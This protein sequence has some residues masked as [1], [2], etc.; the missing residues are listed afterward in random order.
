MNNYNLTIS[1][2]WKVYGTNAKEPV[3][4]DDDEE[5][6][7]LADKWPEHMAKSPKQIREYLDKFV[8]GQD[9]TKKVL[10]VAAYARNMRIFS[11]LPQV[12]AVKGKINLEKSNVL[13]MGPTG[14]GKTFLLKV[15]AEYLDCATAVQD[16]S[17]LSETGYVGKNANT[18]IGALI[19]DAFKYISKNYHKLGINADDDETFW[20]AVKHRVEHGIVYFDEFD[21]IRAKDGQSHDISTTA[22]Q[23]ELLKLIEGD[24]ITIDTDS[25]TSSLTTPFNSIGKSILGTINTTQILFILGGSFHG[26]ESVVSDRLRTSTIGFSADIKSTD[27]SLDVG[28]LQQAITED[29][30]R[31]GIIP[32]LLGRLHFRTVVNKLT[33]DDLVRILIEPE[34]NLIAQYTYLFNL[35]D[36][37]LIFAPEALLAVAKAALKMET[38]ARALRSIL[39][40]TLLELQYEA[41]SD[42]GGPAIVITADMIKGFV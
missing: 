30:I 32:E 26:L 25:K 2:L 38:G 13:I 39:E 3:Q 15:L 22:V 42:P 16:T 9:H 29:L 24:I 10:A 11:E 37:E 14:S 4:D 1:P 33:E 20:N 18:V 35:A 41:P 36:R 28:L 21:K 27:K 17:I 12:Q 31:F 23:E 7:T 34:N 40:E 6:E 8:I 5:E 19:D